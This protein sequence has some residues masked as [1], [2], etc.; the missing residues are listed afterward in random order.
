[1]RLY[2]SSRSPFVRKVMIV[3]HEH[4]LAEQIERLPIVVSMMKTG[5]SLLP[6][7]P[8]G[9][10][11]T[12]VLAD[13]QAIYDSSVICEY[14]DGIGHGPKLFPATGPARLTALRRAALGT[15]LMD[16]LVL[17]L[18]EKR[19]E[20]PAPG[21][22]EGFGLKLAATLAALEA[23]APALAAEPYG[24][25]Q[26]AIGAAL[27]YLDFRWPQEGWRAAHPALA[28]WQAGFT[29][30]AAVQATAHIDA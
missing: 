15:G 8:L 13:G 26:I 5:T 30:R 23:E 17:W 20:H 21:V 19:R 22:L 4:G 10:I 16:I 14:L 27:D 24:I 9:K 1:M 11:P 3:A 25:G 12:L 2:W 29:A 28:A 18:G 6:T 7:N